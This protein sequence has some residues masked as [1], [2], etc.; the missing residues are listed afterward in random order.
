VLIGLSTSG[1]SPNICL[2]LKAANEKKMIT[3]GFTGASGGNMKPLCQY[4]LQAPTSDTPRIQ[5]C[6]MLAGHI[7]CELTEKL[8]FE[9][10]EQ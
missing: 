3:I 8:F 6:H 2:A 10:S 5:E 9:T 1:N 4:L 7:L